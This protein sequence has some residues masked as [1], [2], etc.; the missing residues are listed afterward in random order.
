VHLECHNSMGPAVEFRNRLPGL[1]Q[2]VS[3]VLVTIVY[4]RHEDEEVPQRERQLQVCN[5][6]RSSV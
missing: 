5:V 4:F 2:L 6:A 3:F 1:M